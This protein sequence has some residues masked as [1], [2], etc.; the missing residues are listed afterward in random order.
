MGE[1]LNLESAFS[2]KLELILRLSEFT[3]DKVIKKTSPSE[4]LAWSLLP[5]PL[6]T[7][8]NKCVMFFCYLF[9][10]ISWKSV[11]YAYS[12]SK[13]LPNTNIF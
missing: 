8:C 11:K 10:I 7:E 6:S 9:G 3:V 13:F 12:S 1:L 2:C 4:K 5:H